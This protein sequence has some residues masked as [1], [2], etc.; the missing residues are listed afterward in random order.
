MRSKVQAILGVMFF[1]LLIPMA[2]SAQTGTGVATADVQ[3]TIQVTAV[4]DLEFGSL[5][6]TQTP[7]TVVVTPGG[8][9]ATTDVFSTSPRLSSNTD[10][11]RV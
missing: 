10:G 3:V 11:S 4:A 8:A 7:G 6:P 2:A 9:T 5:V 1:F